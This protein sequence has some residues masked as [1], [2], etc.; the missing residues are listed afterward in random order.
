QLQKNACH[1]RANRRAASPEARPED[2]SCSKQNRVA[3][4]T[5]EASAGRARGGMGPV[6]QRRKAMAKAMRH[7]SLTRTRTTITVR[8]AVST[9]ATFRRAGLN[10]TPAMTARKLG[11]RGK[12]DW[13]GVSVAWADQL[14]CCAAGGYGVC[15]GTRHRFFCRAAMADAT[16]AD[17]GAVRAGR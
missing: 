10:R 17:R 9:R 16:R 1:S 6:L 13:T 2:P 11:S 4:N 14:E 15:R 8:N 5:F 7:A 3:A 12:N